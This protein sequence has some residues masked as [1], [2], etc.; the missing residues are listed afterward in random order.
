MYQIIRFLF[1]ISTILAL[2]GCQTVPMYN[3]EN[4]HFTRSTSTPYSK[5]KTSIL[6]GCKNAGWQAKSSRYGKILATHSFQKFR[7]TIIIDFDVNSYSIHYYEGENLEYAK[8]QPDSLG[9]YN[10]NFFAKLI[11]NKDGT[12]QP[13]TINRVYNSWIKTLEGSINHELSSLNLG[14][15]YTRDQSSLAALPNKT[16]QLNSKCSNK[17]STILA[18]HAQIKTSKANLRAG[19]ST[20]CP[21]IGTLSAGTQVTLLGQLG[22]WHYIQQTNGTNAWIYSSLISLSLSS[23]IHTQNPIPKQSNKWTPPPLLPSKKISIAVIRFKTLN[24]EA[25]DIALGDL[26]SESFTTSLVN[27]NNFKIIEREQLDKVVKEMEM[28]QTG[29]IE[30]TNAVEIGKML[31]ADAII[32]G[33]VALLNTQIH[34]NARIIEIESTYVI[35]AE[36]ATTRYSLSSINQAIN[37][38]VNNLSYKLMTSKEK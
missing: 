25:K 1:V 11:E 34:I 2:T 12:K 18:G 29:F 28:T 26:V 19:A 20:K 21:I 16:L 10:Q 31:H 6:K 32:T 3:V 27:S 14:L 36:S 22:K 23:T 24:K 33:S 37:T 8:N 9:N 4:L 13:E 5:I 38:I 15:P 35:S 17:P 30:A 7:A